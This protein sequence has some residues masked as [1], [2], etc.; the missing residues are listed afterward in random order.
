MSA[1]ESPPLIKIDPLTHDVFFRTQTCTKTGTHAPLIYIKDKWACRCHGN[2]SADRC[3]TH[4]PTSCQPVL[5]F[6]CVM[7]IFAP[8]LKVCWIPAPG[9]GPNRPC[10]CCHRGANARLE[11][12]DGRQ[13]AVSFGGSRSTSKL[14]TKRSYSLSA[15]ALLCLMFLCSRP[16]PQRALEKQLIPVIHSFL[17]W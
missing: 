14:P 6:W 11:H 16:S 8:Q 13:L 12:R 10:T 9:P 5:S 7:L 1:D 4:R 17:R 3:R 2:P 15:P